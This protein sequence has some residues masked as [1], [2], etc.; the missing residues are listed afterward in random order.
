MQPPKNN[1]YVGSQEGFAYL[2]FLYIFIK[3]HV[4]ERLNNKRSKNKILRKDYIMTKITKVMNLL[5]SVLALFYIFVVIADYLKLRNDFDIIAKLK[6]VLNRN[7]K[8]EKC[9]CDNCT[10]ET[11]IPSFDNEDIAF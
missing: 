11:E 4:Y 6:D 5:F 9:E 1:R 8:T 3:Y 10:C 2:L 7:R